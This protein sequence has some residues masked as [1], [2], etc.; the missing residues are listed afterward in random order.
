M[1]KDKS[2]EDKASENKAAEHYAHNNFCMHK[3]NSYKELIKCFL[4]GLEWC[5]KNK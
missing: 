5:K 4:A 1:V 2:T 3:T